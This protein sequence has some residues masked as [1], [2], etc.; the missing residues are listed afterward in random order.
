MATVIDLARYQPLPEAA[1]ELGISP[2]GLRY[3]VRLRP[4]L[5]VKRFG[6]VFIDRQALTDLAAPRPVTPKAG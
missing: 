1:R 3:H 2:E 4:G 6:R 5:A